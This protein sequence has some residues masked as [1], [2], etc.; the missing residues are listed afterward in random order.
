MHFR[1]RM[2]EGTSCTK[3]RRRQ[4]RGGCQRC[5]ILPIN[6]AT[7]IGSGYVHEIS[8]SRWR[9][10]SDMFAAYYIREADISGSHEQ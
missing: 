6:M 1:Y 10:S 7:S 8:N 9:H 4:I 3:E 2:G 5:G